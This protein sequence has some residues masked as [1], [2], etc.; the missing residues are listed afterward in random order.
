M[1]N[2]LNLVMVEDSDYAAAEI[3]DILLKF[4]KENDVDFEITRARNAEELLENYSPKYDICLM[5]IELPG[6]DGMSA[7]KRLRAFDAN[8]VIIFVTNMR[9]YAIAGYE[10][11][12]LNYI[13]KPV[14]YN[15]FSVTMKRAIKCTE[16]S[17]PVFLTA[18]VEGGV[19]L[20]DSREVIYIDIM[21]HDV[22]IHMQDEDVGTYGTLSALEKQ[23]LSCGFARCSAC[24]LVNLKYVKS[25]IKD[26]I[27]TT[28]DI[29]HIS[30]RYR[31]QF[32]RSLTVYLGELK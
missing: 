24:A 17:K 20:I 21:N 1:S 6:M 11:G 31:A 18:K 16:K 12:A 19:R 2:K 30:R 22:I 14:N 23:L 5:D 27:H 32:M 28:R 7:A 8:I 26:D 3:A 13:L 10:V 4:G 9:Q 29:V 15:S 25:V